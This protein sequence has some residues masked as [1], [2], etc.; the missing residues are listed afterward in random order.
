MSRLFEFSEYV[1]TPDDEKVHMH[2]YILLLLASDRQENEHVCREA[3]SACLGHAWKS[4]DGG[5]VGS[6]QRASWRHQMSA[7]PGHICM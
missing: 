7:L 6:G 3:I 1:L 2:M 4:Q 5:V